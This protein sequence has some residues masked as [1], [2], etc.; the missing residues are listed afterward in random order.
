MILKLLL[1]DAVLCSDASFKSEDN[2]FSITGDPTEVALIVAAAKANLNVDQ[3]RNNHP[4]KDVIPF[5][6]ESKIYGHTK[7]E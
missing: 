1:E 2:N 7:S 3:V 6:S 5:D 4:R